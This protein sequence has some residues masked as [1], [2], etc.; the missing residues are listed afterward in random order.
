MIKKVFALLC[1]C[2][3]LTGCGSKNND[4][5]IKFS[6]WGSASEMKI[7]TPIIHEFEQEN[8]GVKIDVMHIPQDYFK[9]LHL[10][11]ASN[12]APDV[13]FINNLNLPVYK[14]YLEKLD[15]YV[16][17]E[18]Y[19][20]QP[21]LALSCDG[22]VYAI[23]R[24]ISIMVIYYNKDIFDKYKV[25]YPTPDW[26]IE[27]MFNTSAKLTHNGIWGISYE[28][29]INYLIPYMKTFG[30]GVLDTNGKYTGEN[31]FSQK[32]IKYYNDLAYKYHYA[33][34]P[35]QTG[36]KTQAQM[37]LEGRLGMHLTGR[38]MVP[39]YRECAKFNWDIVNFPKCYAPCDASGWAVVKSSKH[40]DYAIKFILYLSEKKNIM[41]IS[42]DG[43]IVP[44]RK[45]VAESSQFLSGKPAHSDLFLYSVKNSS[46]TNVSEK[47][48]KI[49]DKLA[50]KAFEGK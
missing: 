5:V 24:D 46:V 39:K 12:L 41:K 35:A 26:T 48:N 10:L 16:N 14:K 29:N 43:L 23:P 6:T 33:P 47:Y 36:S 28:Q 22:N 2:V 42:G 21:L 20:P 31:N 9:K 1:L 30:G 38:W 19:Y 50:D 45:D 4:V 3:L 18:D 15:N 11:F 44:A 25:S 34:T 40:K 37:F 7:L 8:P 13:V 49:A 17:K 27:D 32:G